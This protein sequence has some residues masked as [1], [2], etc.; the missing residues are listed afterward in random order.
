MS[1]SKRS[2]SKPLTYGELQPGDKF[3][4]FPIDGDDRGHG[5]F[6]RGAYVFVKQS[7][8]VSICLLDGR[9]SSLTEYSQ[10][11]EVLKVFL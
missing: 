6:C 10:G 7:P 2:M 4:F 11:A 1:R 3:I 8:V 9:A 5:G